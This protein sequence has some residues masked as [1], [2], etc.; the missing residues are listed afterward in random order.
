M[1]TTNTTR[2]GDWTLLG[3]GSG[4]STEILYTPR[5]AEEIAFTDSATAPGSDVEVGHV[6]AKNVTARITLKNNERAWIRILRTTRSNKSA[7]G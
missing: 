5:A 6:L 1:A 3:T 2:T 7:K 4:T